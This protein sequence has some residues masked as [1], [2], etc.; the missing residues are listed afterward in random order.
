MGDGRRRIIQRSPSSST[1]KRI[2]RPQGS[3][4]GDSEAPTGVEPV[5]EVLQTS[6]LPLG[7]GAGGVKTSTGREAAKGRRTIC[8]A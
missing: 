7:Y 5:M 4:S 3:G 8:G 2:S 6:A 1:R